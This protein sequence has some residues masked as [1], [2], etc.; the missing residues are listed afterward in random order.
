MRRLRSPWAILL[1]AP[2]FFLAGFG[3]VSALSGGSDEPSPQA[4]TAIPSASGPTV[5][6][7]TEPAPTATDSGTD[8][9][10]PPA[11]E[12][13]TVATTP[14]DAADVPPAPPPGTVAVD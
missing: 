7:T 9:I 14:G 6:A 5:P 8:T 2:L 11:T 12:D 1:L 3:I 13:T 10:P 4:A